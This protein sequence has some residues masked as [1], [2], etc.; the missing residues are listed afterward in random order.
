M[1]DREII[2]EL[3]IGGVSKAS[4]RDRLTQEGV[5]LN[6]YAEQLF[7]SPEFTTS[8]LPQRLRLASVSLRQ[9]GLPS[10]GTLPAVFERAVES[11][12]EVCPTEVGPHLRFHH[13]DQPLGPY[14]TVASRRLRPDDAD[15]PAGFY[16]RRLED[17]LWLRGYRADD[18]WVFPPDFTRF[19]FAIAEH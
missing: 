4:L 19:V 15:F 14:L 3:V 11:G 8:P 5:S 18:N 16:L 13:L 2:A 1:K 10:G 17:G 12:Y 7:E 6:A 9:L